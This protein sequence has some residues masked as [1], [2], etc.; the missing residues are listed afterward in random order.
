MNRDFGF[1]FPKAAAP[2]LLTPA[3]ENAQGTAKAYRNHAHARTINTSFVDKV[4]GRVARPA[5]VPAHD[6]SVLRPSLVDNKPCLIISQEFHQRQVW[7]FHHAL[8]GRL[9]LRKGHSPRFANDLFSELNALWHPKC[10]WQIIPLGR[11]FFTLKFSSPEDSAITFARTTWR[12]STRILH[13]QAWVPNFDPYKAASTLSQV[14]IRVFNLSHEYWHPEVLS[15]IARHIGKP[16][17]IDGISA[18]VVVGQFAHILV[19]MDVSADVSDVLD[20]KCVDIVFSIEFGYK[21]LTYLCRSCNIIGHATSTCRIS[22]PEMNATKDP[23]AEDANGKP[24]L[25]SRDGWRRVSA[26]KNPPYTNAQA[27]NV[28]MMMVPIEEDIPVT[29]TATPISLG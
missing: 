16:I 3:A 26:R 20:V 28:N 9:L 10:S 22:N 15:G 8:H 5:D 2:P 24:S 23:S 29:T 25:P 17:I 13:L 11:G 21:N 14:W 1:I 27:D 4:K 18:N 7:S 12:L 19:D 6:F